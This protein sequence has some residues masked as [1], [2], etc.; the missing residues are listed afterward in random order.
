MKYNNYYHFIDYHCKFHH[1]NYDAR[2]MYYDVFC[3]QL[4]I[5]FL[6]MFLNLQKLIY[7]LSFIKIKNS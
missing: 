2:H 5:I 3:H 1:Y 4:E 6:K 7:L